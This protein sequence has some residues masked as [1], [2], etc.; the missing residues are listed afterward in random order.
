M[1][2]SDLK[3][4]RVTVFG[5]GINEGGV[6]TVEFLERSGVREILVTDVKK[7]EDLAL[8]IKRLARFPSSVSRSTGT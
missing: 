6:G 5:L 8:S 2:R 1:K 7:R 4:K 3:G